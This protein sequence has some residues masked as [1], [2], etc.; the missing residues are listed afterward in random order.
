MARSP[1]TLAAMVTTATADTEIISAAS[2]HDEVLGEVSSALLGT[3]DGRSLLVQLSES[4]DA[5]LSLSQEAHALK[6]LTPGSRSVLSFAAPELVA[7]ETIVP[8]GDL[9]EAAQLL[10]VS[11]IPGFR[12]LPG[13]IPADSGTAA[14]LAQA[15]AEVHNLPS[16]I[17]T[18]NNLVVSDAMAA[19]NRARA[20]VARAS[21]TG[22]VPPRLLDRWRDAIETEEIWQFETTICLGGIDSDYF[23][24]EEKTEGTAV[25]GLTNWRGLSIGDPAQDLRWIHQNEGVT[26]FALSAYAATTA[27]RV[28]Y[29]IADRARLYAEFEYLRWLQHAISKNDPEMIADA[30]LLLEEL[31]SN[32]GSGSLLASTETSLDSVREVLDATPEPISEAID[33]SMQTDTYDPAV[34]G[35]YLAESVE[36]ETVTGAD[37]SGFVEPSE[38]NNRLDSES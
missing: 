22:R 14:A 21:D 20:I 35:E 31:E 34:L 26:P 29:H 11:Y 37:M 16:T 32:I 28:D 1:L 9:A 30:V 15:V 25:V 13:D 27:H 10:L 2:F 6:C 38:G 4:T 17:A 8:A 18:D 33:T 5:A 24:L 12:V 19:R 36:S 23:L 7:S 3:S